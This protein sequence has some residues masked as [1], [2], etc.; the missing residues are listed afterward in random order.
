LRSAKAASGSEGEER[1]KKGLAK[2]FFGTTDDRHV[3]MQGK[4]WDRSD[5]LL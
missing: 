2:S 5:F 1:H 4:K 3:V